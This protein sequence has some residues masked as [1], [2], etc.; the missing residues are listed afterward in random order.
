MIQ[1]F[2]FTI[3]IATLFSSCN[4]SKVGKRD[5]ESLT[6]MPPVASMY[7]INKGNKW[8][9]DSEKSD[10]IT[11]SISDLIPKMLPESLI[12]TTLTLEDSDFEEYDSAVIEM[13]IRLERNDNFKLIIPSILLQLLDSSPGDFGLFIYEEGFSR[14]QFNYVSQDLKGLTLKAATFG[15]LQWIPYK[16]SS[17]MACFIIDKKN[18]TIKYYRKSIR[19]EKDPMDVIALKSQLYHLLMSYFQ[20]Q[21]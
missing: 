12:A 9:F 2:L 3:L 14:T 13:V 10:S 4:T 8:E 15:R 17:T 18:K 1:N 5:I 19:K 20:K 11:T 6:I 16:A 7:T 21:R